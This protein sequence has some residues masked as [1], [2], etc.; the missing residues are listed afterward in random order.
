MHLHLI[1]GLGNPGERYRLN[2]HNA[3]FRLV[4]A[5]ARRWGI[6][7]QTDRNQKA[8]VAIARWRDRTVI[9]VKPQAFMN[10]SGGPVGSLMR[11]YKV[12]PSSVLVAFDEINLDVGRFKFAETGSAGGHNGLNDVLKHC[13][14]LVQRLRIGVGGKA[15]PQ[16]TLADWVLTNFSP[17]EL[18]SLDQCIESLM[19]AVECYLSD[20]IA[21]AMNRFHQKNLSPSSHDSKHH[22]PLSGDVHP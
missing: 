22:T 13:G 9:L 12:E 4:E 7:W 18:A 1:A 3:G 5:L 8:E 11:Y 19:P 6:A 16:M 2:R 15:H 21:K 10:A 17:H 14:P 20:G